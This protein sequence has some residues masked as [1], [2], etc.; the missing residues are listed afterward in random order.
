M[1]E[2]AILVYSQRE[3][4]AGEISCLAN[5]S[6]IGVRK[7]SS[8]YKLDPTMED[9]LIRVGGRL[10]K[11]AMP[12]NAKHPILLPKNSP[13][14]RLILQQIHKNLLHSGRNHII[15]KLRETYW[16]NNE[17]S[18]AR[19]VISDCVTC[20]RNRSKVSEQMMADLPEDRLLP[21]DPPFC[22]TG[23]DYFGQ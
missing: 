21:D 3:A 14:S 20:R 10:N 9:G 5:K 1:A 4:F 22:K 19:K 6:G 17:N 13:I 7:T 12:E 15:S 11:S 23:V 8:V 18:A 2:K 16:I